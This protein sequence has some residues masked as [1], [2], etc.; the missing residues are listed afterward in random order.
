MQCFCSKGFIRACFVL[1]SVVLI[2]TSEASFKPQFKLGEKVD[3]Y[4]W[5]STDNDPFLRKGS[6]LSTPALF[7]SSTSFEWDMNISPANFTV[8]IPVSVRNNRSTL[9]GHLFLCKSGVHP[10]PWHIETQDRKY[11]LK[12]VTRTT[13]ITRVMAEVNKPHKR[14]LIYD[15]VPSADVDKKERKILP[16]FVPRLQ[17]FVVIDQTTYPSLSQEYISPFILYIIQHLNAVDHSKGVYL[18]ILHFD[19]LSVLSKDL[20]PLNSSTAEL[21]CDFKFQSL[22]ITRYEWMLKM[23]QS[24][25][26]HKDMGTPESE[27][28]EVRRSDSAK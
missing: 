4:F 23:E 5:I 3:V 16:H 22:G 6:L 27:M 18:P 1:I 25:Q 9:F 10:N 19:E 2:Q 12:V 17:S 26:T 24:V 13:Q 21:S 14:N 8:K 7:N 15:P 28:E 11:R 20:I